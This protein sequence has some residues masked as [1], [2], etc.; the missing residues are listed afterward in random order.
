MPRHHEA[1]LTH[2]R[3]GGMRVVPKHPWALCTGS[4]KLTGGALPLAFASGSRLVICTLCR[5]L[6]AMPY[7]LS[8]RSRSTCE[9]SRVVIHDRRRWSEPTTWVRV[10]AAYSSS[11]R[12][13]TASQHSR[14]RST[15]A[16]GSVARFPIK[17]SWSLP[18]IGKRAVLRQEPP[19]FEPPSF[20]GRCQPCSRRPGRAVSIAVMRTR[21]AATTTAAVRQR[22]VSSSGVAIW[23]CAKSC[24]TTMRLE[25]VCSHRFSS[26]SIAPEI[27]G[28]GSACE[29][30][31]CS[32]V[33]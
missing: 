12:P 20:V 29:A 25:R 7:R 3:C 4:A 16:L 31:F 6:R 18:N 33:R 10:G 8:V 9:V 26:W 19:K 22:C 30:G 23:C 15:L 17:G 27:R 1:E 11:F 2:V 14:V 21:M 28:I 32:M 24:T 5:V 13:L